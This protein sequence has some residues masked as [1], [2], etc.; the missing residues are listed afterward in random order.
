MKKTVFTLFV[1]IIFQSKLDAQVIKFSKEDKN[2]FESFIEKIPIYEYP[3][4]DASV[5]KKHTDWNQQKPDLD[6]DLT[7]K[8]LC[9]YLNCVTDNCESR[10]FFGLTGIAKFVSDTSP[11]QMVLLAL[12]METGCT[13]KDYLITYSP[14]SGEVI[15]TLVVLSAKTI[16]SPN[17]KNT[18]GE[19]LNIE[20]TI[21]SITEIEILF[22]EKL[23]TV[24]KENSKKSRRI[25]TTKR[26]Y[27]V[28]QEGK[29]EKIEEF[30]VSDQIE[31]I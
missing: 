16:T 7:D 1:I 30:L 14:L 13:E 2:S 11:Y 9:K 28:S 31:Q 20:C 21:K 29:F 27:N 10:F 25:R 4:I 18:W 24:F 17:E 5:Y 19:Y 8:Y 22:I 15:D 23:G 26:I 6:K 3:V 12:D